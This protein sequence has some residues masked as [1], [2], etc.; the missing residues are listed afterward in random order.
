M[1]EKQLVF[2]RYD[3]KH[4][5]HDEWVY[6]GADIDA[7][8]I[9]W[10]REWRLAESRSYCSTSRTGVHGESTAMMSLPKLDAYGTAAPVN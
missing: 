3:P 4:V 6:K 2:V 1:P 7:S 8:K 9:V 5:P 10:A